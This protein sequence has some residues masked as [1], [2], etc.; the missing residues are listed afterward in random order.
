MP[1]IF[2]THHPDVN[3]I[4]NLLQTDI[5]NILQDRLV[6]MYLFG[7]LAN[8]DFD[9]D[10]DI[11]VLIV[12]KEEVP[13]ETFSSLYSMHEKI[14]EI[15]SPW[16]FQLEVSY[17]PEGAL[18]HH[19]PANNKHPRLDRGRDE[20]LHI[21]GH[22]SDWIIQRYILRERGITVAGPDLESLI[23]PVSSNDLKWA[24]MDV[25]NGWIKGFLENPHMLDKRGYQS[26]TVLTLCRI[27]YTLE[28]G[29]VTSKP[30]AADWAKRTLP[31]ERSPLIE[32][33]WI[34]RQNPEANTEPKD[35]NGTLDFIRYVVKRQAGIP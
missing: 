5:C 19:D 22:D 28:H 29:D 30:V 31:P 9:K 23:D 13:Q 27:L 35:L 18:R 6:G 20:K 2:P 12:T 10:S 21:T 17:I 3:E 32:R 11:D 24:V 4:L 26:Y 7:S 34:G 15:D 8:G 16:A 25:L 33:A 14:S 1:T